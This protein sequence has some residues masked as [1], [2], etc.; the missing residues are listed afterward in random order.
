MTKRKTV[1]YEE[2]SRQSKLMFDA[3]QRMLT[4]CKDEELDPDFVAFVLMSTGY[5][6]ALSS[7][8]EHPMLVSKILSA[9]IDQALD[10]VMEIEEE[11]SESVH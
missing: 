9:A 11:K 3:T 4:L 8:A 2:H 7:N 6:L 1:D 5:R 10:D